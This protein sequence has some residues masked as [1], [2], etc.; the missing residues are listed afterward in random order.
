MEEKAKKTPIVG[1]FLFSGCKHLQTL[2]GKMDKLLN[3][4]ERLS[5]ADSKNTKTK[6]AGMNALIQQRLEQLK[7]TK[8]Q[9]SFIKF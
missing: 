5:L 6:V 3:T 4:I 7:N 2:R 8:K 9:K 1:V